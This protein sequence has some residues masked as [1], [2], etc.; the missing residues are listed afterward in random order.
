[1]F[2]NSSGSD[3]G[4]KTE[5]QVTGQN[6]EDEALTY[7]QRQGLALVDRNVRCKTGEI[8]LIMRHG[9]T[10]VFV[11][12]RKRADKRHGG[13]AASVTYAKQM[14]LIRAAQFY[15]QRFR[16]PPPCRFDVVAIDGGE[17]NWIR[18]AITA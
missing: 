11:E 8:D 14:K 5:K 6:G 12:V 2:G 13:A 3:A 4:K 1:M 10:L 15:L 16:M 18:N 9:E 7:L 17:L